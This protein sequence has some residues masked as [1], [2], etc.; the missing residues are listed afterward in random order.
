MVLFSGGLDSILAA[1]V[2]QKQGIGITLLCFESY[3]FS[4]ASARTA[5]ESLG[6][7]LKCVN[8]A[9]EQLEAVKCPKYGRGAGINPCIDCHLLMLKFAGGIMEKEGLDFVVTGE[10]LGQRPMSQN[11]QSLDLIERESGLAGRLLR[12]LSARLLPET[13]ME[14]Q[15][16]VDRKRLEGISG[17]SRQRQLE[18]ANEFGVKGIPQPAGGCILTDPDFS[19]KLVKLF[20][21]KPDADGGDARLLSTGRIF[22][23]RKILIVVARDKKESETLPNFKKA[24]DI[25]AVPENFPGPTVLIRGFGKTATD[26]ENLAKKY[27]LKY[28]KRVPPNPVIPIYSRANP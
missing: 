22:Y 9:K 10:V 21:I 23:D 27:L 13:E 2:L 12:P 26:L 19:K 8:F 6:L 25:I 18:L 28:S 16:L 14:K 15:K 7:P 3:F 11:K 20:E 1:K 24:G 5:A 17:R 4:C